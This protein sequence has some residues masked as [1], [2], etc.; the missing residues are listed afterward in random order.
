MRFSNKNQPVAVDE[1]NPYW[2]S[3]SDIMA[4]LLVI[5][6]L[7]TAALILELVNKRE[8]IEQNID[9][10]TKAESVRQEVL[11]EIEKDLKDKNIPI[12]IADND[13]VLRIPEKAL[14]FE[15]SRWDISSDSEHIVKE[16]GETVYF[17]IKKDERW[18]YFDT[19]FVEGHTDN[20]QYK[21][22]PRG[23]WDLSTSRAV[24]IWYYW[25]T[26]L[27][28]GEALKA[29]RNYS[30]NNL[31]SVSGYADTRL[32]ETNCISAECHSKNRRI[33]IRFTVKKPVIND[34]KA[35]KE[36]LN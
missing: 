11:K 10:L 13:T 8:E 19:I 36:Q 4:S 23:N 33:D 32:A 2:M 15:S 20:Q 22:N 25:T 26:Q 18:Q 3:F 9:E 7:A 6:I 14:T 17:H 35:I 27:N 34:Y 28:I 24:S 21:N 29:Q 16:I 30:G 5:F 31:F 1:E 12:E